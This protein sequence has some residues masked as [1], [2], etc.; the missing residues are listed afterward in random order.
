MSG[1]SFAVKDHGLEEALLKVNHIAD[2]PMEELAEGIGRLV[3]GQTRRRITDEKTAPDGTPWKRNSTGTST[4]YASGALARSID[5][6]ASPDSIEI[7][8]ALV[9]ARI[10][11]EGGKIVAKNAKALAFR[12]GNLFRLVQSV[13]MP[14]RR[15]LGLSADNQ[16]EIVETTEDWLGRL[17]Q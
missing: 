3:Q 7:G 10:H 2:A 8:S 6:A 1:V 12:I 5:Y 16:D 9:Y 14:M 11:Q 15:Y 4:L 13:T 17:L